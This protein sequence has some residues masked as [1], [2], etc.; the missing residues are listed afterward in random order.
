MAWPDGG[1]SADDSKMK[2]ALQGRLIYLS[3]L[4]ATVQP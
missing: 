4:E 2:E 1:H 3:N